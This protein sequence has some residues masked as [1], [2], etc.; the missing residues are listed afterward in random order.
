MIKKLCKENPSERLGYMRGGIGEIRNHRWFDG[1]HWDGLNQRTMDAPYVPKIEGHLDAANF[2][3]Y[4][5]E[6][7][8]LCNPDPS[9][10]SGW[11]DDF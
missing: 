7:P 3:Q 1:F 9:I 5:P 2:D 8:D 4:P 6:E 11:D 10:D